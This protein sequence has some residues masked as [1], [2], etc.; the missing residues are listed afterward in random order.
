MPEDLSPLPDVAPSG[1]DPI[2]EI[3]PPAA[4]RPPAAMRILLVTNYF[5]PEAG[6][7]AVRL[8]R[9][10]RRLRE[11]GHEITVLTSLPHYPQGRIHASHRGRAVVT[12][13]VD[14]IRVVQT[15]ILATAS[16]RI[17][18]KLLSQLSFMASALLFGLR[19]PRPDVVLVEAQ[20]VFTGIAGVLLA[21][22]K[23]RPYVLNVSDLW[24][25]HLLSVGALTASHPLYRVARRVVDFT[26]RR[27]ERIVAMS[28]GWADAI[29]SYVR[30]HESKISIIYN[31]VDLERF[32]PRVE[33]AE[34]R[35]QHD[36][37]DERVI[38]FVGTFST[39][40]DFDA[41]LAVAEHFDQE[42]GVRLLFVGQGSQET[43]LR[44]RLHRFSR[45]TWIPWLA[46]E[47]IPQAWNASWLTYWA[48]RD[49]PLYDGTI[50][51]KVYEAMACGVPMVAAMT[52]VSADIIRASGAGAT[53]VRGDVAGLI[54]EIA[55][56]LDSESLRRRYSEAA[57]R[58]AEMHYDAQRAALAYERTLAEAVGQP[59]KIA[60]S[61]SSEVAGRSRV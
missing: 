3:A 53:V 43:K 2:S 40:Y 7:A 28:P 26:Y 27:A 36:L 24:P 10:A 49:H 46:H 38:S 42:D 57:R 47:E 15:W 17:G 21:L 18:R 61:A 48:L 23:R 59:D 14:G 6:A 16:P 12:T 32:R 60:L 25:D 9:L 4:K 11:R 1:V 50:P 39:Q 31:G 13:E 35:R 5:A 54:R 29:A 58:Y 45:L 19:I 52:G 33:V 41:T 30:G 56:V 20:P 22:L 55:R 44:D 34:F 51:A 37:G 8:T